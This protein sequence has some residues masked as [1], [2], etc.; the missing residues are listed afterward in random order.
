MLFSELAREYV[1]E[2]KILK[3]HIEK[4]KKE[5]SNEILNCNFKTC[6]RMSLLNDMYLDLKYTGQILKFEKEFRDEKNKLGE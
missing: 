3:K 6:R 2:A 5:L 1:E 4:L